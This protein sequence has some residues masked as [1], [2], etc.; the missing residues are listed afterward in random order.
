MVRNL[1]AAA[2]AMRAGQMAVD[3]I[4]NNLAN[5]NTPGFKR[6]RVAFAE[7][8]TQEAGATPA[9]A[10]AASARLRSL[11]AGGV[12]SGAGTPAGSGSLLVGSGVGV[13]AVERLFLQGAIE[14]TG[15]PTDLALE[16]PGFFVVSH[17][18]AEP[19]R[20]E[21][22]FTR[23]GSFTVSADG[24]L[25]MADGARLL[26]G[27]PASPEPLTLPEGWTELSV[28][29]AGEVSVRLADGDQPQVVGT[30]L[31]AVFPNPGGL[32]ALG[33]NLYAATEVA[34]EPS[35]GSAASGGRAQVV[36]GGREQANV[37]LAEELVN[38]ILAQ[39]AYDLGARAV[40]T[41]D[42]MLGLANSIRR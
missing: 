24:T 33:R 3:V 1:W 14:F 42:E 25:T 41:A 38:L 15:V 35:L 4:A 11:V 13:A 29:R 19:G 20:T 28:S 21:L 17:P 9:R 27:D 39:R 12:P 34:G 40:R 26:G 10:V 18:G 5:V 32:R 16:G 31:V 23:D 7:L 22:L 2:S 37:E 8:V 6:S 30:L 36:Q